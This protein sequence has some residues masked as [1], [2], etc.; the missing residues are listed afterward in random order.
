LGKITH[1][2]ARGSVIG[3]LL[4]LLYINDLPHSINTNNKIVLFADDTSLIISN[5]ETINFTD[6]VNKILQH[7]YELF[8]ANWI[9]LIWEK[10]HFMHLR[11]K[12]IAYS[13]CYFM[14]IVFH[15]FQFCLI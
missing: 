13:D 1:G 5:P 15:N 14:S 6:D 2:V 7:I 4:F 11:K 10:T 8:N 9:S 12:Q 3:S